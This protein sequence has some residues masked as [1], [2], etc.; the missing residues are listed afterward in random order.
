MF[1]LFRVNVNPEMDIQSSWDMPAV[2]WTTWDAKYIHIGTGFTVFS[3]ELLALK[4]KEKQPTH[5]LTLHSEIK[6]AKMTIY[7][8]NC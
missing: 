2:L 8:L 6:Q 5:L 7:G 1:H 3:K 4:I